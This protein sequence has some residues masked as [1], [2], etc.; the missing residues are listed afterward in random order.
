MIG[1]SPAAVFGSPLRMSHA[2][3]PLSGP[4]SGNRQ[5]HPPFAALSDMT[6]FLFRTVDFGASIVFMALCAK[7]FGVHFYEDIVAGTRAARIRQQRPR[8]DP[9]RY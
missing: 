5:N 7:A 9:R 1:V 2:R 6:R 8:T 4:G 3:R